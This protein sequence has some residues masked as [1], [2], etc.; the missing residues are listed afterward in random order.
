MGGYN[1]TLSNGCYLMK[2]EV[3]NK[4]PD[5]EWVAYIEV[6]LHIELFCYQKLSFVS[7]MNIFPG[8]SLLNSL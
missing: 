7:Q 3:A 4:Y 6:C 8:D 1:S 2:Y 5:D